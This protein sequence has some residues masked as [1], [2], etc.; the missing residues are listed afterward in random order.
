[1]SQPFKLYRLQ[2]IDS[3]IDRTKA[4]LKEIE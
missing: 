1:M 4:R 3:Q 2:Q